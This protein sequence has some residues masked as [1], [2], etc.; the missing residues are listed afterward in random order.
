VVQ[1][2]KIARSISKTE[3]ELA[4]LIQAQDAFFPLLLEEP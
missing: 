4:H 3:Y 2:R 1:S